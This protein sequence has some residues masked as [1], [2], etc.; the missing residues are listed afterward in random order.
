MRIGIYGGS[1]NPIHNGHIAVSQFVIEKLKLDKLIIVP[2]GN[3]S[4]R[5]NNLLDGQLRFE[6]CKRAFEENDKIEVSDIEILSNQ[7]SYTYD[8]LIKLMEKYK[9]GDFYEIIGEDSAEYFTKWKEYK[10]ILQL[11]TVVVLKRKGYKSFLS[12]KKILNLES[13]YFNYS[14][15]EIRRKIRDGESISDF[16]PKDIE[17]LLLKQ[18]M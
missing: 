1:F 14:S 17:K 18:R 12:G 3:P 7:K 6:M 15:T 13:P 10:K 5:D 8:T 4:H 2:V 9:D 11:S 16:V